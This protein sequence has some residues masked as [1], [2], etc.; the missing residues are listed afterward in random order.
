MRSEQILSTLYSTFDK[1]RLDPILTSFKSNELLYDYYHKRIFEIISDTLSNS[2]EQAIVDLEHENTKL[3]R[4]NAEL[5]DKISQIQASYSTLSNE[6]KST[7]NAINHIEQEMKEREEANQNLALTVTQLET[8][9]EMLQ[10]QIE[11]LQNENKSNLDKINELINILNT[12]EHELISKNE[13]ISFFKENLQMIK[14]KQNELTCSLNGMIEQNYELKNELDVKN[15]DLSELVNKIEEL[16]LEFQHKRNE[17]H[18]EVE[19]LRNENEN[20]LKVKI[21]ALKHKLREKIAIIN[22]L[23]STIHD[24]ANDHNN[25]NSDNNDSRNHSSSLGR[26]LQYQMTTAGNLLYD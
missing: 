16:K 9:N 24:N 11:E 26:N 14:T 15:N 12:K 19:M 18:K 20:V 8:Q 25:N 17:I 23:S 6:N 3:T 21:Q 2:Q 13:Q 1:V 10:S 7:V 4:L 22:K 5:T